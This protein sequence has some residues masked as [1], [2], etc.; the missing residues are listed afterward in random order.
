MSAPGPSTPEEMVATREGQADRPRRRRAAGGRGG[1]RGGGAAGA[2]ADLRAA[3]RRRRG[4]STW[5]STAAASSWDGRGAATPA[6]GA[7]ADAL[8]I[9]VVS[10]DYRLAPEDPCPAGPDDCEAAALWLLENAEGRFGASRLAI[11]GA[12]SGGNL[13]MTTLLR[14]RDRGLVERFVGVVL[15]YGA[16]D[17]SG[18]SPGGRRMGEEF[19]VEGLC[20]ARRGSD[21]PRHLAALR[22]PRAACRPRSSSSAPTT[23]SS[24]T[25]WR[26]R[27][28]WPRPAA[29]ST[30][31]ST[32][33]RRTASARFP[34][35]M[36][37]AAWEDI[38][39]WLGPRFAD[40][41]ADAALSAASLD[42]PGSSARS[43]A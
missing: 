5:T 12:S 11:G 42:R 1:R 34:I 20:R 2:G 9:A 24:R 29:R 33:R 15:V 31:V 21:R 28:A 17:L 35:A 22:R 13:A 43:I 40:A 38:E 10:V 7:L 37:R 30:C 3:G 23:S 18:R 25:A 6:T 16:F 27:G 4:A 32:P 8:G 36:G 14:L 41:E 19:L 26:W 39:A